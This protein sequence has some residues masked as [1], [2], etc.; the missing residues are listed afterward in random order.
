MIKTK[1]AVICIIASLLLASCS[2]Y[3]TKFKGNPAKGTWG[4]LPMDVDRMVD[5]GDAESVYQSGKIKDYETRNVETQ[6]P[7]LKNDDM[8]KIVYEE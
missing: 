8:D 4:A 6:Y 5:N 7:I 1:S 2:T 3:P